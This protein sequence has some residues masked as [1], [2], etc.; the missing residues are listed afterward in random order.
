M[1]R[2]DARTLLGDARRGAGLTQRE[3]SA[4]SGVPQPAISRIERGA[5]S[6]RVETLDRLL[7]ACGRDVEAF[8]RAGAGLDRTLIRQML[9]LSLD[10]RARAA[11]QAWEATRVFDR[12][13][14]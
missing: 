2:V 11:V 6:P 4:R 7:A 14:R 8:P 3:L 9:E 10:E 1:P 13:A 12:S 5:V